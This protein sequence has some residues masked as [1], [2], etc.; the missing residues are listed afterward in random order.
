MHTHSLTR[1]TIV[2]SQ[3][4]GL[5]D[6]VPDVHGL[7]VQHGHGGDLTVGPVDPQPVSGV[8][9]LGVPADTVETITTYLIP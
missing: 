9:Q 3:E 5:I 7:P 1:L 2:G 4:G 6:V 8:R